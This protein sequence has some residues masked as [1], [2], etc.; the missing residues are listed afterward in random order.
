[1]LK[2]LLILILHSTFCIHHSSAQTI[3]PLEGKTFSIKLQITGA[4][5]RGMPWTTDEI[6]FKDGKLISKVMGAKEEFPPFDCT[7]RV[8]STSGPVKIHFTASGH[9]TGVS[10]ITWEGIV[11]GNKIEGTAVWTNMNGPQTQTFIG[12]LKKGK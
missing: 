2:F 6:S 3:N 7:F 10:Y 8:D 5:R 12:K 4:E 1:M 9:N 11:T